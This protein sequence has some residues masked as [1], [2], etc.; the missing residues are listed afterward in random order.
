MLAEIRRK[1]N[2]YFFDDDDITLI[3]GL[4]FYGVIVASLFGILLNLIFGGGDYNGSIAQI[5]QRGSRRDG[6]YNVK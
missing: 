1:V 6:R 4:L 3:D 5:R 2:D